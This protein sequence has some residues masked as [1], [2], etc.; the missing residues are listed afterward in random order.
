M[1]YEDCPPPPPE[2]EQED[3]GTKYKSVAEALD[4]VE[5][6]WSGL[7]DAETEYYEKQFI[8]QRKSSRASMRRMLRHQKNTIDRYKN[9]LNE[10]ADAYR[11]REPGI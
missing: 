1:C 6:D 2:P 5:K 4:R 8:S 3:F 10:M 9:D 7:L 11:K